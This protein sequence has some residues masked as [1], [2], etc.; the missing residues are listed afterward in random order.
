[1]CQI[2][3]FGTHLPDYTLSESKRPQS[4]TSH[5]C[6][7][8]FWR[9][10]IVSHAV[11]CMQ[12]HGTQCVS[13][14]VSCM[15]AH[16]TQIV[17]NAV[18]CMEAHGTQIVSHAVCCMQAHSTQ[19]VSHAVSCM[20]VHGTQIVSHAVC[21]IQ[22]HSNQ[23]VS[24]ALCSMQACHS[25]YATCRLFYAEM[26]TQIMPFATCMQACGSPPVPSAI[27]CIQVCNMSCVM[28]SHMQMQNSNCAKCCLL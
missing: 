3:N 26:E 21:S 8:L 28:C 10:K 23:I 11:C 18:S 4:Q 25:D 6:L 9:Y 27:Y 14:A 16:G 17:S 12:A 2:Q 1:M 15:Q 22:A 24:H 5:S 13:H 19:I 7:M 20:E